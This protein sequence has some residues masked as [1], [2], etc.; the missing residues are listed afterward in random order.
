MKPKEAKLFL[1]CIK[2]IND[3]YIKV[4]RKIKGPTPIPYSPPV[5]RF[6]K[7]IIKNPDF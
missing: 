2:N 6:H 1:N 3:K 5:L 4:L 7:K